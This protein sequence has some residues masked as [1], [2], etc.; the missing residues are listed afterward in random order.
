MAIHSLRSNW[1]P[2][3]LLIVGAFIT[4][5]RSAAVSKTSRSSLPWIKNPITKLVWARCDWCS[6]HSR[7]PTTWGC[8]G[9]DSQVVLDI[10]EEEIPAYYWLNTVTAESDHI[11]VPVLAPAGAGSFPGRGD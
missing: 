2:A 4:A 3:H 9:M 6:A 10:A 1:P 7:A 5:A 11:R 8:A